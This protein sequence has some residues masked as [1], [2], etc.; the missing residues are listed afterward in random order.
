MIASNY[1]CRSGP[2]S[3]ELSNFT[4]GDLVVIGA[5]GGMAT[6]VSCIAAADVRIGNVIAV[7]EP[8]AITPPIPGYRCP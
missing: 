3:L 8:A 4:N 1:L 5:E 7:D 6:R 2:C